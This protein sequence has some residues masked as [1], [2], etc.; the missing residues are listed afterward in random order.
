MTKKR[1]DICEWEH[2]IFNSKNDGDFNIPIVGRN[3]LCKDRISNKNIK[4]PTDISI[5]SVYF[6]VYT[7]SDK[8][9]ETKE[10]K[11]IKYISTSMYIKHNGIWQIWG[12]SD[13]EENLSK[14]FGYE[15]TF[16][17]QGMQFDGTSF[18]ESD[19]CFFVDE[20]DDRYKQVREF[21]NADFY[22]NLQLM[23]KSY[24]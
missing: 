13:F 7:G 18:M 22:E 8:D 4:Y 16:G 24:E 9:Y 15:I 11:Y 19:M 5:Y 6:N 12:D 20:N 1:N 23:G 10:D 21:T 2:E 17:E 3:A 14:K